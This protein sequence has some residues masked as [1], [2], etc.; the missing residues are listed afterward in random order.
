MT[1][2]AYW[3]TKDLLREYARQS[4]KT[5]IPLLEK[6]RREI[7]EELANRFKTAMTC[8]DNEEYLPDPDRIW[9][10]ITSG[11]RF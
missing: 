2:Y 4:E 10:I 3:N 8:L 1:N 5:S 11:T 6:R 7:R 9:R